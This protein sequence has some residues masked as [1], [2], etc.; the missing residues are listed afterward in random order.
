MSEN[1]SVTPAAHSQVMVF[2]PVIPVTAFVIGLILQQLAPADGWMSD[3]QR[4]WTRAAGA[5]VF[6]TG[7]AGFG[8]MVRT[9][10]AAHTPIHNARPPAV[11]VTDGPFRWTRNPM[12]L[13]GSVAYL[14]LALLLV[15]LWCVALLPIALLLT[16]FGVVLMEERFL[17]AHFGADYLLYK[18]RVRRW[19]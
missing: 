18:A 15:Q 8:W 1:P 12:Y 9:M 3:S 17:E 6:C 14:G 2:P 16:H 7:V 4:F 19:L 11:L 13:F 5:V 10:K